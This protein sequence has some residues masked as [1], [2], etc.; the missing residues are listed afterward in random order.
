MICVRPVTTKETPPLLELS[1]GAGR[2]LPNLAGGIS[3]WRRAEE[4]NRPELLDG[5]LV[6]PMTDGPE[7]L[8]VRVVWDVSG[9]VPLAEA[10][11][12][13]PGEARA[14]VADFV[15]CLDRTARALERS[16]YAHY[17][18]ALTIP[19]LDGAGAASYFYDP[20]SG[21]LRVIHWG[22]SAREIGA[23]DASAVGL[24]RFGEIRKLVR[25][26]DA[27]STAAR[28]PAPRAGR[29]RWWL[30]LALALLLAAG[31]GLLIAT[32][33]DEEP[34]PTL[35][36][37]APDPPP[38]PVEPPPS[39]PPVPTLEPPPLPIP[40]QRIHFDVGDDR[41]GPDQLASLDAVRGYM[42]DHP[43]VRLLLVEGHA[44]LLG[45]EDDNAAL[46]VE[47]AARVI[48]WLVG[49]GVEAARLRGAGCSES[50]PL[51]VELH[52]NR[53]VEFRVLDP[54]PP[55][56]VLLRDGCLPVP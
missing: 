28:G 1:A 13:R 49:H 50:Y 17:R 44:D 5:R 51:A 45:A 34:A 43:E 12:T 27:R 25:R 20:G 31:S 7:N 54:A 22:A 9:L 8:P 56:G 18:E 23:A 15:A 24:L 21:R 55:G 33:T 29:S 14:A 4:L 37:R 35:P 46:S 11:R 40:D 39:A 38:P 6:V 42:A 52:A 19:D 26:H 32:A 16:A 41:L 3:I 30:L 53:R 47:R 36:P 48:D 2:F 10:R